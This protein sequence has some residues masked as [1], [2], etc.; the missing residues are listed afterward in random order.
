MILGK[1][2]GKHAEDKQTSATNEGF[3]KIYQ[4]GG[5][6]I[7]G[8]GA[9]HLVFDAGPLGYPSIAAHGHADALS[10]SLALN[11]EWWLVDPGTYAYHSE[12]R[13]RDYFRGTAAHNT[14]AVDRRNQSETGGPFLWVKHARAGIDSHGVVGHD[15]QWVEGSHDGYSNKGVIHRRK[16]EFWPNEKRVVIFDVIEGEGT[17]EIVIHFHFAPEIDIMFDAQ[18]NRWMAK[19]PDS[20]QMLVFNVDKSW[21]WKTARGS[22]APMRGWYSPAL[23]I[24]VPA[25]TLWGCWQGS[26]PTR[27][28]T[29]IQIIER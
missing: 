23:G 7:L 19:R 18:N 12:P 9:V 21:R 1:L 8:N 16:I 3:P 17:H 4:D 15:C 20:S 26:A 22:E 2:S 28:S 14:L 11:G 29:T 13:W 25:F 10:F 5:Y 24:K 6:A 27:L